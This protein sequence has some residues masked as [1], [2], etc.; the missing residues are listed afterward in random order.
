MCSR[1]CSSGCQQAIAT[2]P[3]QLFA[4]PVPPLCKPV[5]LD[6]Q[7]QPSSNR[8]VV[9]ICDMNTGQQVYDQGEKRH[10]KYG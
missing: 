2:S 1:S 3:N 6:R 9:A 4:P 5:S 8:A 7:W 10:E